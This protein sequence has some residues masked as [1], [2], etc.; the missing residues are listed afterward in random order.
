MVVP[1]VAVIARGFAEM[2]REIHR[3][4]TRSFLPTS[5]R[6]EGSRQNASRYADADGGVNLTTAGRFE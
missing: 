1:L 5:P 6:S 2:S 3:R 4:P